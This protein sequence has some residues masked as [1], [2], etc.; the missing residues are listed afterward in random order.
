MVGNVW[1]FVKLKLRIGMESEK[2]AV[3]FYTR[4]VD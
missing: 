1:C 4:W 2:K 3:S